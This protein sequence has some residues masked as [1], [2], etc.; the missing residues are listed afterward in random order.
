MVTLFTNSDQADLLT[1]VFTWA[2]P[3]HGDTGSHLVSPGHG[4]SDPHLD[5]TCNWGFSFP[6]GHHVDLVA[7]VFIASHV[8]SDSGPHQGLTGTW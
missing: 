2:T 6:H 3:G 5:L 4:E 7:A 8:P 1:M